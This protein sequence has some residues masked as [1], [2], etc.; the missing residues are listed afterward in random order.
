METSSPAASAAD[1][2]MSCAGL[3]AVAVAVA[4][5]AP[6]AARGTAQGSNSDAARSRS[7]WMA[8]AMGISSRARCSSGIEANVES[9]RGKIAVVTGA[10]SGIGRAIASA[11]PAKGECRHCGYHEQPS[12]AGTRRSISLPSGRRG[13]LSEDRRRRWDDV[14]ALIGARSSVTG[15]RR[16]VN[17]AAT[18]PAPRCCRRTRAMEQV[19]RV[20]LTA[21][22]TAASARPADDHPGA[23]A[24]GPGRLINL[25]SQQ[26]IVASPG[27]LP[28]G[29][30][31]AERSTSRDR[32]PS[33]TPS[34]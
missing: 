24:G 15:A 10:S 16:H 17:N 1:R 33:T 28:Y 23:A 22:S 19:M 27:D 2:V 6:A 32:L 11:S 9:T 4:H 21:Y 30:S 8:P 29:V 31:K 20:N 7:G 18:Y 26:G 3:L 25:G 13:A 14:D 34:S 12:K 5:D